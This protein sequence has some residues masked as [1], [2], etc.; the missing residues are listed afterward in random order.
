MCPAALI[1]RD[2]PPTTGQAGV[3]SEHAVTAMTVSARWRDEHGEAVQKLKRGELEHV[4]S[5][6]TELWQCNWL[7]SS[8]EIQG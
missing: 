4:L 3:G 2:H 5:V 7:L 6:G 1:V 8:G